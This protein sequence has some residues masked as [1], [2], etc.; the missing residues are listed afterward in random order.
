ME[1]ESPAIDAGDPGDSIESIPSTCEATDQRGIPRPQGAACDIGAFELDEIDPATLGEVTFSADSTEVE[2]GAAAVP[3]DVIPLSLFTES[4]GGPEG[5]PL[6]AIPLSAIGLKGSPLSAIPLSAIPLSAIATLTGVP[7]SAILLSDIPLSAIGG[8]DDLLVGTDLDGAIPQNTT[9]QDVLAL[10]EPQRSDVLDE[11]NIGDSEIASTLLAE[12]DI[13]EFLFANSG[14]LLSSPLSAIGSSPDASPLSAIPLSAIPL[15]AIPLSA[16][17]LSAIDILNSPL[18]AI[19]LSAIDIENSPL[20]AIPL[21]AIGGVCNPGGL[22]DCSASLETLGDVISAFG[23]ISSSPLSA[24]PLSAI[25]LS[26]IPADAPL[27]AIPLSAIPLSAIPLSAIDLS[28]APLSAIPL[29]AIGGACSLVDCST[30]TTLAD[31]VASYGSVDASPLS[32]IPLS[33]IAPSELPLSAIPLSAIDFTLASGLASTPLSAIEWQSAPL[34]AIPLSAIPLSAID[35]GIVDCSDPTQTLGEIALAGGLSAGATLGDLASAFAAFGDYTLEDL[36]GSFSLAYLYGAGVIGDPGNNYGTLSLA[37]LLILLLPLDDLPWQD[38]DPNGLQV[39][40]C[41]YEPEAGCS[42]DSGITPLHYT[43]EIAIDGPGA[44]QETYVDVDLPDDFIYLAGSTTTT[45]A[46]LDPV[47]PGFGEGGPTYLAYSLGSLN[48]GTYTLEFDALAGFSLGAKEATA[49]VYFGDEDPVGDGAS[50][51]VLEIGEPNPDE[52]RPVEADVLYYGYI[53]TR[54]DVDEF[55][56]Q[57]PLQAGSTVSVLVGQPNGGASDADLVIYKPAN[58][59]PTAFD[60]GS[61]LA[62]VPVAADGPGRTVQPETIQDI[63]TG[64]GQVAAVSTNRGTG[65][66]QGQV[67]IDDPTEYA[68]ESII[69]QV[70]AY[71]ESTATASPFSLFIDVDPPAIA[72]ICAAPG[73]YSDPV[74]E[75][76]YG[77]PTANASTETLILVNP[78]SMAQAYGAADT[79]TVMARLA[80]FASRGDVNGV[81]YPID[82][83]AAVRTALNNW[84]RQPCDPNLANAAVKAITAI[85]DDVRADAPNLRYITIIGG[86]EMVP[87]WREPDLVQ[88]SKASSYAPTFDES[89]GSLYGSLVTNNI[90]T[91]A[92]YADLNPIPFLSGHLFVEDFAVGRVVEWPDEIIN[93]IDAFETYNGTLDI[94]TADTLVTGYD[95]LYDG[96]VEVNNDLSAASSGTNT[97]LLDPIIPEGDPIP[98]GL[99]TAQD[100]IDGLNLS[101]DISSVNAHYDHYRALPSDQDAQNIEADLFTVNDVVALSGSLNGRVYYTMGC[102][103]GV[104]V[105]DVAIGTSSPLAL[106]WAQVFAQ[107]GASYVGNT[108]FGFG[109]TVTVAYSERLMEL[110]TEQLVAGLPIGEALAVAKNLYYLEL[111]LA[112]VY[113]AHVLM[114]ATLYGFP[115]YSTGGGTPPAGPPPAVVTPDP[116]TGQPKATASFGGDSFTSET[117]GSRQYFSLDGRAVTVHDRPIQPIS[118][119]PLAPTA[120]GLVPRGAFIE[121]LQISETAG[122]PIAFGRPV[123]DLAANEPSN[124]SDVFFPARVQNVACSNVLGQERCALTMIRGQFRPNGAG[125]GIGTERLITSADLTVYYADPADPDVTPPTF[126]SVQ[127]TAVAGTFTVSAAITDDSPST[128]TRAAC[129]YRLPGAAGWVGLELNQSANGIWSSGASVGT[130]DPTQV[131][132]FCQA[133][134][135]NGNLA[136]TS[137]K[138]VN[139]QPVAQ[140][141]IPGDIGIDLPAAGTGG[142]YGGDVVISVTGPVG[143]T[144]QINGVDQGP[145]VNGTIVVPASLGT[146]VHQ[147][148]ILGGSAPALV[149]VP[150]DVDAPTITFITP[151]EGA[152]FDQGAV[153]PSEYDCADAGAGVDTCV[154]TVVQGDPIDSSSGSKV[155]TVTA[156]DLT[157]KTTVQSVNYTVLPSGDNVCETATPT[158]TGTN[159]K[160]VIYGTS[161]DDV[162]FGLGG[163]DVLWGFGG[164]DIICGGPGNDR[165]Y[166]GAGNDQV[167]GG[168]GN[169]RIWAGLQG[170]DILWGDEGNDKLYGES[171]TDELHGGSG[172]DS[173]WGGV[174][175]DDTLFGDEGNDKLYGQAGNDYLF[176]GPGNDKLYGGFGNDEISGEEG[177]DKLYGQWG[178]DWLDGG[179]TTILSTVAPGSTPVPTARRSSAARSSDR[180]ATR[181]VPDGRSK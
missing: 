24:I 93:Q 138:G 16:I 140:P 37:D 13:F 66:E 50:V 57:I 150:I 161:G 14:L 55:E 48:P 86:D 132:V 124:P 171:G 156:T 119:I 62:T 46:G 153:V 79:D 58:L 23:S 139:Y 94:D 30:L 175:G 108:S 85:V 126:S 129:H 54:G 103:S 154:G 165:I 76:S 43:V 120:T 146:D 166:A 176:G 181:I 102:N 99:W 101:P 70:E 121:N 114:E 9:L 128:V 160:D 172:N 22:V 7:L 148:T 59:P 151:S 2:A 74:T 170:D 64:G 115:M 19:P 63:P 113:D 61:P 68:G 136:V 127:A 91:D 135:H 20:S 92:A 21:S 147:V 17:P 117:V 142:W 52:V 123:V 174:L 178:N 53:A 33:A 109:D 11:I 83:N 5:A 28:A 141:D 49:T 110:F 133:V 143:L 107:E 96:S 65:N 158:H 168:F 80:T 130:V 84:Y 3:I 177:N 69:I 163:N 145:V 104:S 42:T 81:V 159:E 47:E 173:L 105:S 36:V 167:H 152:T 89:I 27:S 40:A 111:G 98:A 38:L 87:M 144:Y 134:D 71:N 131:E 88:L 25:P 97:A 116:V 29:S 169:D 73:W 1:V 164:N 77:V 60:E 112:A 8:W 179:R 18:S 122:V 35:C 39:Y 12:V 67:R 6:S 78:A 32:A 45:G 157:G 72:P 4:D 90:L 137:F 95:F 44:G 149:Y 51:D 26:A 155:F 15:S 10:P 162:I 100:V 31:V 75:S 106:D 125:E 180:F 56:K 118:T 34:S 41:E 82:R